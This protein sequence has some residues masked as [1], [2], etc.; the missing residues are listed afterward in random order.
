MHYLGFNMEAEFVNN[1]QFRYVLQ[2]A[3]NR[4]YA[5]GHAHGQRAPSPPACPFR[6]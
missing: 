3:V 4:D 6:R 5:G 2:M 1:S